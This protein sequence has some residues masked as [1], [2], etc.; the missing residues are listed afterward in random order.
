MVLIGRKRPELGDTAL[1]LELGQPGVLP[2]RRV[3][4][5]QHHGAFLNEIL[6]Q[7]GPDAAGSDGGMSRRSKEPAKSKENKTYWGGQVEK[8][9]SMRQGRFDEDRRRA[10]NGKVEV[11]SRRPGCGITWAGRPREARQ[12]ARS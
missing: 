1:H 11:R 8:A 3:L 12:R 9:E 2:P 6:V 7:P 5:S 4:R 10:Q